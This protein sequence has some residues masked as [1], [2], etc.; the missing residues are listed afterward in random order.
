V[1]NSLREERVLAAR[2]AAP[3]ALAKIAEKLAAAW[4][5][6]PA[7]HAARLATAE[8]AANPASYL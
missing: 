3:I 6:A 1:E 7:A 4:W 2:T 5:I 8:A